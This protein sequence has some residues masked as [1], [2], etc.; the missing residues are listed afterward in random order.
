LIQ[1][2]STAE[3]SPL[4]APKRNRNYKI[5]ADVS[6]ARRKD[7]SLS[8]VLP[9]RTLSMG[10]QPPPRTPVV[11]SPKNQNPRKSLKMS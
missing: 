4:L 8:I 11:A 9:D 6:D 1:E 7:I 2:T 10:D 3:V 5:L